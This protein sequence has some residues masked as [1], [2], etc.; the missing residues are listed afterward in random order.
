MET[1]T[2]FYKTPQSGRCAILNVGKDNPEIIFVEQLPHWMQWRQG[3]LERIWDCPSRLVLVGFMDDPDFPGKQMPL[4]KNEVV[5][6]ADK[7]A[8]R[9]MAESMTASITAAHNNNNNS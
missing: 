9:K 2:G 4:Y 1:T 3:A 7:S 5:T 6:Y 8:Y